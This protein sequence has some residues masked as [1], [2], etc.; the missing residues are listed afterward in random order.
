MLKFKNAQIINGVNNFL[1]RW[2]SEIA[3]GLAVIVFIFGCAFL[4]FPKYKA[5]KEM[6]RSTGERESAEY[7]ERYKYYNQLKE[8]NSEYEKIK[9]DDIDKIKIMAPEEKYQEELLAYLEEFVL[10]NGLL[11]TSAN[12]EET[13]SAAEGINKLIIN[14]TVAGAD[15]NSFKKLLDEIE[16]NLRILDVDSLSFTPESQSASFKITAYYFK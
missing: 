12:V 2:F 6:A 16:S 10:K 8:L 9:Q 5:I 15:Y 4:I 14:L 13:A 3:L 1:N 11:L 7:V